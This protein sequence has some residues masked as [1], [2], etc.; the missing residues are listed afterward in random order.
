LIL[1]IEVLKE[2]GFEKGVRKRGSE[3]EFGKGVWRRGL[4]EERKI[5]RQLDISS[6][7]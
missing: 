3:E 2:E 5:I 6:W 7:Y 1:I 4:E